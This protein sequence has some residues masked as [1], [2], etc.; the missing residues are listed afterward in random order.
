MPFDQRMREGL[1]RA[2]ASVNPD[3]ERSLHRITADRR[4]PRTHRASLAVAAAG[5]ATLLLIVGVWLTQ[6]MSPGRSS[7][8]A[9]DGTLVGDY[10]VTLHASDVAAVDRAM[11]GTWQLRL[12]PDGT[13]GLD[14]PAAFQREGSSSYGIVCVHVA[15]PCRYEADGA[16]FRTNLELGTPGTACNSLGTYTWRLNGIRLTLQPVDDACDERRTLLASSAWT[17]LAGPRLPEGT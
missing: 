8:A 4:R 12:R 13:V 1:R 11:A 14:P 2:A 17:D 15:S 6:R 5:L 10:R 16:T 9:G 7:H 3:V